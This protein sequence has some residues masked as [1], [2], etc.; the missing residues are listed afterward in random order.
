MNIYLRKADMDDAGDVLSWRNDE[1]TRENS[2]NHD[3][4]S[5]LSH[6]KW[7]EKKLSQEGTYMFILMDGQDKVGHIR[8]DVTEDIGEISYMIAPAFRGRG[9][10]S[11]AIALVEKEMPKEVHSLMGLTLKTNRASGRCFEK[12]G[13]TPSD[14]GDALCYSK[15]IDR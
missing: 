10:G 15:G 4:I 3:R 8:V 5:L 7:F 6:M 9:Y 11:R 12:N 1:L 2:F 14:A 13:Y